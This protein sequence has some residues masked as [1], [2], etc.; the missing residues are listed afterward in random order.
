M[1]FPAV[2]SVVLLLYLVVAAGCASAP[3]VSVVDAPA[4]GPHRPVVVDHP[5]VALALGGGAARGFAHV[6]VI[7]ALEEH[8]ISPDIVVGTSAGSV[9][10]SLYA[11]GIRGE[12]LVAAALELD[13]KRLSDWVFP[14]RGFIRGELLQQYVNE[15][16]RGRRIQQLDK[17]FAAVATD[18][19]SGGLVAFTRGDTGMAVRASSSVPGVFQPVTIGGREYVD[20][21]LVSPVPVRVARRMGADIVIAVDVSRKARDTGVLESTLDVLLQTIFIMGQTIGNLEAEGAEVVIRPDVSAIQMADFANRELAI[22]QGAIAAKNAVPLIRD[23]LQ[24]KGR[25]KSADAAKEGTV[26][27]GKLVSSGYR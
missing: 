23:W 4:G 16:L 27:D 9:V 20:G 25:E 1:V 24:R 22:E 15:S 26:G 7:K 11:G 12:R 6:G 5:V 18:L 19:R 3:A 2:S 10:G 14:S 8:G 21:G 17:V 13:E